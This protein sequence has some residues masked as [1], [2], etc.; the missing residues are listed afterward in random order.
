MSKEY[1]DIVEAAISGV[2]DLNVITQRIDQLFVEGKLTDEERTRVLME[3]R[4]KAKPEDS[5]ADLY[6]RV[7]ANEAAIAEIR[8]KLDEIVTPTPS[9]DPDPDEPSEWKQPTSAVDCYNKGD[10]VKYNDH[11]YESIIDGNVWSPDVYPNG[12][13]LVS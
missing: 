13:K 11:I 4:N 9:P 1:V 5:Y 12:W 3:A 6:S 10:R 7:A 2:F 8:K